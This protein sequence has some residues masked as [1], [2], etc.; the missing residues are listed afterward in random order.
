MRKVRRERSAAVFL[1][2][3]Q[4]WSLILLTNIAPGIETW[5]VVVDHSNVSSIT[6]F[7]EETIG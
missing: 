1:K 4:F 3:L 5:E 7:G 2:F 6:A